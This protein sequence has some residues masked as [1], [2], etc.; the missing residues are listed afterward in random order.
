M[1]RVSVSSYHIL[2]DIQPMLQSDPFKTVKY[3]LRDP[4]LPEPAVDLITEA[5]ESVPNLIT[6][7]YNITTT[8]SNCLAA[9]GP[10]DQILT[11]TKSKWLG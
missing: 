4:N 11:D 6:R 3:I 2:P 1:Q 10:L 8:H 7:T 5:V 9:S